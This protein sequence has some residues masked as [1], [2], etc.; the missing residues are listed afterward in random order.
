[1]FSLS[2][3]KIV[4]WNVKGLNAPDKRNRIKLD[5]MNIDTILLQE[6]KMSQ[7]TFEKIVAKWSK[8]NS[9]HRKGIGASGG[10]VV[11]WNYAHVQGQLLDQNGNWQL[12]KKNKFKLSFILINVYG[13]TSTQD[14]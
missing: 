11:L 3:M 14:K 8:W 1:M 12:L 5:S 7:E 9:A 2:V 4:S 6:T 10:I 13:P